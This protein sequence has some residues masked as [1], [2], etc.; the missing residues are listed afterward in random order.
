LALVVRLNAS[1]ELISGRAVFLHRQA[2]ETKRAP[3]GGG[4]ADDLGAAHGLSRAAWQNHNIDYLLAATFSS[5]LPGSSVFDHGPWPDDSKPERLQH[6]QR[7][8]SE[9]N[10]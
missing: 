5:H 6:H 9:H 3:A 7:I 8:A 10:T 2:D 1:T 4:A